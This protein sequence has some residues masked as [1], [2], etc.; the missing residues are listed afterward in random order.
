MNVLLIFYWGESEARKIVAFPEGLTPCEGNM[1]CIN[2][3]S[4]LEVTRVELNLQEIK[5]S[6]I[7][8]V[9]VTLYLA[10][11]DED[12]PADSSAESTQFLRSTFATLIQQ[13][14][15]TNFGKDLSKVHI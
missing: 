14:W 13:G 2:K 11:E 12:M 15:D 8:S 7:T 3:D 5:E 6:R 9:P 10:Y 1:V 4:F